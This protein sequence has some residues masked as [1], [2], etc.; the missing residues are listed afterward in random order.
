MRS[1]RK[2]PEEKESSERRVCPQTL[3]D[4]AVPLESIYGTLAP[5]GPPLTSWSPSRHQ[6]WMCEAVLQM[7]KSKPALTCHSSQHDEPCTLDPFQST[8]PP[9]AR[10][11]ATSRN[12]IERISDFFFSPP[13]PPLL[14]TFWSI[15]GRR[16]AVHLKTL[17]TMR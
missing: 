5:R 11:R 17:N 14:E 7:K 9:K 16:L 15:V 10:E 4:P 12:A 13:P 1:S 2:R 8:E 3:G 6:T